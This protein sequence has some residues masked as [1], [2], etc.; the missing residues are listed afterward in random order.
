MKSSAA[1]LSSRRKRRPR[2]RSPKEG[3]KNQAPD[4]PVNVQQYLEP[5]RK[6]SWSTERAVHRRSAL[7]GPTFR[8]HPLGEH[9]AVCTDEREPG[10]A[11]S[12]NGEITSSGVR[13]L[14]PTRSPA[15][16]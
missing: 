3:P 15:R 5:L 12:D 10:Q 1:R 7:S 13:S 16:P 14:A 9:L 4:L 2:I 11:L 8:Q 6:S